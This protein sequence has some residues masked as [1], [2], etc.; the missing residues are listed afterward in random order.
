MRETP[1]FIVYEAVSGSVRSVWL[2]L[3]T[4][5]FLYGPDLFR[6]R[7]AR[8]SQGGQLELTELGPMAAKNPY[9]AVLNQQAITET[10]WELF[11]LSRP[12]HPLANEIS[13]C[14]MEHVRVE[15]SSRLIG[16]PLPI[17]GLRIAG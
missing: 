7:L 8:A 4:R 13:E 2:S 6:N 15:K 9:S 12:T 17:V 10:S 14:L 5:F 3:H 11:W 1:I 16:F